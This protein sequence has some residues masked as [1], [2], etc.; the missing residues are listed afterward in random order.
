MALDML[1]ILAMLADPECLF[2]GV[3]IMISDCWNRLGIFTIEALEY[4]KSWL[5]IKAIE[6]DNDNIKGIQ[7]EEAQGLRQE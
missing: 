3:K 1:L 2:L 6:D 5:R 7:G 4:L